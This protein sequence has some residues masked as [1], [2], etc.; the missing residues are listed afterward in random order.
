MPASQETLVNP[1]LVASLYT[2]H[3]LPAAC[4]AGIPQGL[5]FLEPGILS[6]I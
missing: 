3:H 2:T 1:W 4:H 6:Y 5:G